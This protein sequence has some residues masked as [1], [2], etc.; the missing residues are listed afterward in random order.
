MGENCAKPPRKC[1]DTQTDVIFDCG[2]RKA[3][4]YRPH[5][6]MWY[7]LKDMTLEHQEHAAAQ[8]RGRVH[9]F[10]RQ[11]VMSSQSQVAEYYM[12]SSDSWRTVQKKFEFDEPLTNLLVSNDDRTLYLLTNSGDMNENCIFEYDTVKNEWDI[13]GGHGFESWGACAVNDGYY[14]YIIGGTADYKEINATAVVEK[15]DP[16]GDR[17][18]WEYVAAMN[19]ARHDAFGVAMNGKIFAAGGLQNDGP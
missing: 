1:L 14:L 9:V 19:E 18:S 10:S 2:G 17:C 13:L 6:D 16:S 12:S 15:V 7:Q 8:Y 11:I 5:E 4:C 3:S